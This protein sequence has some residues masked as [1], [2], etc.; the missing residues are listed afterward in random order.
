MCMYDYT[1]QQVLFINYVAADFL[2]VEDFPDTFEY[3]VE[4]PLPWN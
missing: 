1:F 3:D 4:S 2:I